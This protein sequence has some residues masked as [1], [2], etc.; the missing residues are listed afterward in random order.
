RDV[1]DDDVR[2]A[3]A[4]HHRVELLARALVVAREHEHVLE[5][6]E[7]DPLVVRVAQVP[8]LVVV[9]DRTRG[10]ASARPSAICPVASVLP[11][12]TTMTSWSGKWRRAATWR[13][14]TEAARLAASFR[15]GTTTAM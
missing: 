3:G 6:C 12:S 14:A 7:P 11:S 10:S 2:G 5:S 1:V 13:R 9:H 4:R 8:R 15:A